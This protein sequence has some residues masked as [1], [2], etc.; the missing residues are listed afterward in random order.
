MQ[1]AQRIAGIICEYNPFHNGHAYQI[2]QVRR[3]AQGIVAV[4]SGNFTQRGEPAVVDKFSR[5]RMALCGGADLVVEL[6]VPYAMNTAQRFAQGA[7]Q[8]LEA[9]GCEDIHAFGSESGELAQLQ[10]LSRMLEGQQLYEQVRRRMRDGV[11]FAQARQEAVSQLGSPA[12]GA[13]LRDPND[14]LGVEYL[15]ALRRV[16]SGIQPL[17]IPRKGA[18]HDGEPREGFASAS[19][20]RERARCGDWEL[21]S[22]YLPPKSL[23][24]LQREWERGAAPHTIS[25][26]E[27]AVLGVL[28]RMT[29]EEWAA[30]PD[31]GEGIHNRIHEVVRRQCS[32]QGI[33][34]SVQTKRYPAARIRRILMA[35]YLGIGRELGTMPVPYVRV[36]GLNRTGAQILRQSRRTAAVPVSHRLA[37]LARQ[38]EV[39][40]RFS[41]IECRAS[42]LYGLLA[43]E[44][45]APCME[46]AHPAV[47]EQTAFE[48]QA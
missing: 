21:L 11:P 22:G 39:C 14:I 38:G 24:L 36:L 28:R 9:L 7:V 33:V 16:G 41:E 8:V 20:I 15:L 25:N 48:E 13:R 17:A 34:Q 26:G 10:E 32:V 2:Q 46:F 42:E 47:V 23:E 29:L 18:L 31:V 12:L 19:W 45:E 5:T 37:L 3:C 44:I 6:P 4:M 43:P 27:R 30:L 1:Q 40:R 35:G